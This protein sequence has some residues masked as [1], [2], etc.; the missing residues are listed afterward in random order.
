MEQ[1][2]HTHT[3]RERERE[4]EERR[5]RES[6]LLAEEGSP[7]TAED[8]RATSWIWSRWGQREEE[9]GWK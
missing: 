5:E 4:R 6:C 3:Q 7:L 2:C 1:T 8:K 9:R